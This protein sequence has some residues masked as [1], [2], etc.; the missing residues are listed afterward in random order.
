MKTTTFL[1]FFT[2]I[3]LFSILCL[4][5]H[6]THQISYSDHCSSSV[7]ESTPEPT[8]LPSHPLGR[9]HAVHFYNT[10]DNNN[11]FGHK[12][13]SF[14]DSFDLDI[15]KAYD[16]ETEGVLK[17]EAVM[18]VTKSSNKHEPANCTD[19]VQGRRHPPPSVFVRFSL[20]GFWSESSGN[21]CM[22]GCSQMR[23]GDPVL[24]DLKAVL[25]KLENVKTS[26]TITTLIRG[27]VASL[28]SRDDSSSYFEPISVLIL[29]QCCYDSRYEYTL[30]PEETTGIGDTNVRGLPLDHL[31]KSAFCGMGVWDDGFSLEYTLGCD[32]AKNCSPFIGAN[33]PLSN[34]LALR[35]FG[36]QDKR[37]RVLIEFS[38]DTSRG[39]T[40][41]MVGQIW[42][43]KNVNNPGYFGK[44]MFKRLDRRVLGFHGVRYEYTQIDR[45]RSSCPKSETA[46]NSVDIYPHPSSHHM[47]FTT[48]IEDSTGRIAWGDVIFP[49]DRAFGKQPLGSIVG[50]SSNSTYVSYKLGISPLPSSQPGIKRNS[51]F[52]RPSILNGQVRLSAEGIYNTKSGALCMVG[53]R[54]LRIADQHKSRMD[55]QILLKFQFPPLL[56]IND[57]GSITGSIESMRKDSDPFYFEPLQ[58][59]STSLLKIARSLGGSVK[60]TFGIHFFSSSSVSSATKISYSDHCSSFVP[61]SRPQK[62]PLSQHPLGGFHHIYHT[63]VNSL[64]SPNLSSSSFSHLFHLDFQ[65]V[66]STAS[67]AV[68]KVEAE[69][70]IPSSSEY[71]RNC[72]NGTQALRPSRLGVSIFSLEGFWSESSGRLCMVGSTR[73]TQGDFIELKAVIKLENVRSS[74]TVTSLIRGNFSSLSSTDD[75]TY[76]EP[77]SVF[78]LP[79]LGFG[80][81]YD[82]TLIP[83]EE[84]DDEPANR[85][86]SARSLPLDLLPSATFCGI[87][88]NVDKGYSLEYAHGC[89]SAAKIC[90]PFSATEEYTPNVLVIRGY[91]CEGKRLR[92]L[93]EF[94][95]DFLNGFYNI[96]DPQKTLF[97]EAYWD[98]SKLSI[99]AC[100]IFD[101]NESM[102]SAPVPDCSTRM[103][104]WFPQ[105]LTIR[106]N[107]DIVGQ[108]WTTKPGNTPGHFEKIM[109]R[110]LQQQRRLY[111]SRDYLPVPKYEYTQADKVSKSCPKPELFKNNTERYPDLDSDN[112]GFSMWVRDSTG[113]IAWGDAIYPD[114]GLVS[115]EGYFGEGS[116]PSSI[117]GAGF[118]DLNN[119]SRSSS[120][121]TRYEFVIG[122][123][124][125]VQLGNRTT[126]F[127]GSSILNGNMQI[128][129][130]GIYVIT[131]GSLCMVG[132]RNL[133]KT[134]QKDNMDCEI[135]LNFRLPSLEK[136]GKYG[137]VK[138]NIQSMREVSDPL[139][140]EPLSVSSAPSLKITFMAQEKNWA[141]SEGP[142]LV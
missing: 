123:L 48:W 68:H 109:F 14:L 131:T 132:C 31:T 115:A 17:I 62:Y 21:L 43:D 98:D 15:Q 100:R 113:I 54:N 104:L 128:S 42:T 44:I 81:Y 117:F 57:D 27:T 4:T 105:V 18:T 46:E 93:V 90:S 22:V 91:G 72:S 97:G 135:L 82:Y 41:G 30:I 138:G 69:L 129:A 53:C 133:D 88:F 10:R 110:N 56:K 76:F 52:N 40:S 7:P 36:C 1:C 119:S 75:C 137:S 85:S 55:C 140:F 24:D 79:Q 5:C 39:E 108:I 45:V 122:L 118:V 34:V 139:F 66:Y 37:L 86:D 111:R 124:P 16:T 35:G 26:S 130:E 29:P 95:R 94:S 51:L 126:M 2:S 83:D 58:V 92:V 65:D 87:G 67:G 12:P 11:F 64:L 77:I 47:Q 103:S 23:H 25:M 20:G 112:M 3:F 136:M 33:Q 70:S 28:S 78:V 99:F 106:E 73:M 96:V 125:G 71:G 89:D 6:G 50:S 49:D 32:S 121:N 102:A 134:Y 19:C 59:S 142:R 60:L 38:R 61:E 13:S 141:H 63:G 116:L 84:I 101:V 114:E 8:P 127:N 9:F 80:A 107:S 120:L 74:S